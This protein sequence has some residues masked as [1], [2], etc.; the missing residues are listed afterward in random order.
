MSCRVKTGRDIKVSCSPPLLETASLSSPRPQ[1]EEEQESAHTDVCTLHSDNRY[2]FLDIRH[3]NH[4]GT[5]LIMILF[6][7]FEKRLFREWSIFPLG[8]VHVLYQGKTRIVASYTWFYSYYLKA[9]VIIKRTCRKIIVLL[10][11]SILPRVLYI[12]ENTFYLGFYISTRGPARMKSW[13]SSSLALASAGCPT[14]DC[15]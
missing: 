12:H 11:K 9:Q 13:V 10:N 5:V 7:G 1:W 3:W 8:K 14:H 15:S 2:S 6:K 4:P